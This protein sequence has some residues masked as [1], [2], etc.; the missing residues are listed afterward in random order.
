MKRDL[1]IKTLLLLVTCSVFTSCK[2][3]ITFSFT[4]K[5]SEDLLEFMIP[6]AIFKDKDGVEQHVDLD[7][8]LFEK[9]DLTTKYQNADKDQIIY[10]WTHKIVIPGKF[11][12]HDMRIEYRLRD[13]HPQINQSKDYFILHDLTGEGWNSHQPRLVHM[14]LDLLFTKDGTEIRYH[15]GSNLKGFL[16]DI[17]ENPD[18]KL[19]TVE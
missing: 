12:E 7:K 10:K 3:T 2:E 9:Y 1:L 17:A 19:V 16:D 4:A 11:G 8:D 15:S 18:Y 13:E 14:D 6:T 5:C